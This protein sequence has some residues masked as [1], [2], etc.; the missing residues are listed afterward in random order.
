M[1]RWPSPKAMQKLRDRIRE[2][3]GKRNSGKDVT[4]IIAELTPILR[5]WGNY[6]SDGER[7]TESAIRWIPSCSAVY[8]VGNFS[9][10]DN[11]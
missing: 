7:P 2:I 9:V 5:G 10:A 4:Q 8:S 11:G 6:F 3:T 1:L